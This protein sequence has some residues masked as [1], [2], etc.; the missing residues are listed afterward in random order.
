MLPEF[1]HSHQ[2]CCSKNNR[3]LYRINQYRP[4]TN[5]KSKGPNTLYYIKITTFYPG[6]STVFLHFMDMD[7]F[8]PLFY[9][10]ITGVSG[11]N[12]KFY[13][14]KPLLFR[15]LQPVLSAGKSSFYAIFRISR[16]PPLFPLKNNR[17]LY[18][19][20]QYRPRTNAKSKG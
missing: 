3:G 20:N 12:A 2:P 9:E 1:Q 11:Q 17:G 6:L 15:I 16:P 19:I 4:R 18:R 14:Q 5:A 8:F 10:H 7:L 13:R